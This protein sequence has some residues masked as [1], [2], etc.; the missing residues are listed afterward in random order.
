MSKLGQ[1]ANT[2]TEGCIDLGLA[3]D[4]TV[5]IYLNLKSQTTPYN[6]DRLRNFRNAWENSR[7]EDETRR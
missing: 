5:E 4:T 1:V 7:G 2:T 3:V 6:P